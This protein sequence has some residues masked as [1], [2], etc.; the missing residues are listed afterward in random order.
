[1]TAISLPKTTASRR[2]VLALKRCFDVVVTATLLVP[3]LPIMA[4]IALAIRRDSTGPILYRQRR[5]GRGEQPF[6]VLKFRSMRVDADRCG[7]Q[8]TTTDDP[9]I[10]RVGQFLRKTSLD[11]LPQLLNVLKGD[12]SLLGPRPYVG[13]ELEDWSDED[14]ARRASVRPGVSGLAQVSGRSDLK[15]EEIRELDLFYVQ[16]CSMALDLR[17]LVKT[18]LSVIFRKGVN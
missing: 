15:P 2:I 17:I 8:Y 18:A 5:L 9:R 4:L 14:R 1:M 13:F 12:M 11:E 6:T 7:P 10:T 16:N 3:A